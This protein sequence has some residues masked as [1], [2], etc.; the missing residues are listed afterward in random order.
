[1]FQ[2]EVFRVLAPCSVVEGYRRFGGP[3]LHG[4]TIRKTPT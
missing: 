3:T 1:M 2:V 4:V